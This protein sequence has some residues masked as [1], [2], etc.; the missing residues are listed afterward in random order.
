MWLGSNPGVDAICGLSLLLALSLSG[1]ERF[2]S[3]YY[4]FTLSLKTNTSKFQS[5]QEW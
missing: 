5:D 1:S 3:R 2:F 4:G